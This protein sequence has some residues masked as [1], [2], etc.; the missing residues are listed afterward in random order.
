MS[1]IAFF[2]FHNYSSLWLLFILK[3]SHLLMVSKKFNNQIETA[4]FSSIFFFLYSEATALVP[5]DYET[6]S[7][8][9]VKFS[10]K[11]NP[12]LYQ[13]LLVC[14]PDVSEVRFSRTN[15]HLSVFYIE[16]AYMY[17]CANYKP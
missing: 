17:T 4:K 1:D 2:I 8:V 13:Y 7:K 10:V 12:G 11:R 16:C 5:R 15:N 6:V 9:P 3:L 14:Q